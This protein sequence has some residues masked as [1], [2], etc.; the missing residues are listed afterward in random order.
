MDA[1]KKEQ[2]Q[3]NIT[4]AADGGSGENVPEGDGAAAEGGGDPSAL[5][6]E[7]VEI[8]V[9]VEMVGASENAKVIEEDGATS[10]SAAK[11]VG[12]EDSKKKDRTLKQPYSEMC[13]EKYKKMRSRAMLAINMSILMQ[14]ANLLILPAIYNVL[15]DALQFSTAQLGLAHSMRLFSM[16]GTTPFWAYICQRY[17]RR[18]VLS[19][20]LIFAGFFIALNAASVNYVSFM[21][22]NV[23]CGM[24]TGAVVPVS[25]SLVPNYFQ[26]SERGAAFGSLELFGGIGGF[27]GAGVGVVLTRYGRPIGDSLVEYERGLSYFN[28]TFSSDQRIQAQVTEWVFQDGVKGCCMPWQLVFIVLGAAFIPIALII[29]I[30]AVDPVQD[31]ITIAKMGDDLQL[32]FPGLDAEETSSPAATLK[33]CPRE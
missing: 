22:Y 32:V 18:V 9:G 2:D 15:S 26:L 3:A 13:P 19:T 6:P 10:S 25:R 21:A 17:S 31:K 7:N 24:M 11:V 8:E 14:W 5:S 33:R 20:S 1:L 29:G 30:Y 28:A 12:D 4:P 23:F 27:L 16:F